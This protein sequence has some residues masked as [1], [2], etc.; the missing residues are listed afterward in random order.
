M[1]MASATPDEG[2]PLMPLNIGKGQ[3]MALG[4]D[5]AILASGTM[6]DQ[7]LI[8]RS[9]LADK[10]LSATVANFHTIKPLDPVLVEQL[11]Q[12]HR[13][14]ITAENHSTI[15]GLGAAV[16]ECL[17]LNRGRSI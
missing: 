5:V 3:I 17:G 7:A 11:A 4:T 13:V 10:G 14:L 16:A 12:T 1:P 8:A 9:I 15:G 6:V 2:I